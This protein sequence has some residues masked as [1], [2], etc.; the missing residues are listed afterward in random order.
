MCVIVFGDSISEVNGQILEEVTINTGKELRPRVQDYLKN[1]W[2]IYSYC[3]LCIVN[4]KTNQTIN[5]T[6]Q[7][8]K[9]NALASSN[10]NSLPPI[11]DLVEFPPFKFPT[12]SEIISESNSG[13]SQLQSGESDNNRYKN[14][15]ISRSIESTHKKKRHRKKHTH[16]WSVSNTMDNTSESDSS[17]MIVDTIVISSGDSSPNSE[18][19]VNQANTTSNT[20]QSIPQNNAH[21]ISGIYDQQDKKFYSTGNYIAPPVKLMQGSDVPNTLQGYTKNP[22]LVNEGTSPLHPSIKQSLKT[23]TNYV[24][25]PLSQN[26]L[27][28]LPPLSQWTLDHPSDFKDEKQTSNS[29]DTPNAPQINNPENVASKKSKKKKKKSKKRSKISIHSISKKDPPQLPIHVSLDFDPSS[30]MH[31]SEGMPA[32]PSA[33]KTISPLVTPRAPEIQQVF[34]PQSPTPE[35]KPKTPK[36]AR[37]SHKKKKSKKSSKQKSSKS[38]HSSKSEKSEKSDKSNP[39]PKP[40]KPAKSSKS[41]KSDIKESDEE[42]SYAGEES[43]YESYNSKKASENEELSQSIL[44]FG[45]IKIEPATSTEEEKT[46]KQKK[47]RKSVSSEPDLPDTPVLDSPRKK[48]KKFLRK[49]KTLVGGKRAKVKAAGHTEVFETDDDGYDDDDP[50]V[51]KK[52]NFF[53]LLGVDP[54]SGDEYLSQDESSHKEEEEIKGPDDLIAELRAEGRTMFYQMRTVET[55]TLEEMEKFVSSYVR[56]ELKKME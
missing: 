10:Q 48:K 11:P 39:V 30:S 16:L 45:T 14:Q 36:K 3:P 47:K 52:V 20:R 17:T 38:G 50:P 23:N 28:R 7:E 51:F 33:L 46:P 44:D 22:V 6:S 5:L 18:I 56:S 43:Q 21:T 26:Y 12:K 35:Q 9:S 49:P 24:A 37:K 41:S 25:P 55:S 40:E 32:T 1:G 31:L 19:F 15:I 54:D 42:E 29:Q 13:Y 2:I 27:Q 8:L 4:T 34:P 53:D